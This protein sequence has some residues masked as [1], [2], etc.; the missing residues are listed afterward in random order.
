MDLLSYLSTFVSILRARGVD[1]VSDGAFG[2][3]YNL[4][5]ETKRSPDSERGHLRQRNKNGK[6][7]ILLDVSHV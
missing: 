6:F 7:Q 2:S 5:P 3:Q 4:C 1:S